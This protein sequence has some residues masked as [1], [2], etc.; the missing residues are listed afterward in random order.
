MDVVFMFDTFSTLL[1]GIPLTLNLAFTSLGVGAALA[2]GLAALRMSRFFLLQSLARSYVF[3]FRGTPLLIQIFLIYY[4]LGQFRPALQEWGLWGFFRDPYWCVIMAISLNTAAYAS[5]I[6][7]GAINAVPHPQVEAARSLGMSGL[8]LVRRIYFPIALRMALPAYGNEIMLVIKATSLA[9]IVTLME[10]T[11]IAAK[12]ILDSFRTL[13]VFIV[14]GVIYFAMNFLIA[15]SIAALEWWL[16]P[17]RLT[18]VS[19]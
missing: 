5:E 18:V 17:R 1:M 10:I 16:S 2:I 11:G 7:R 12:L 9:S 3:V 14:A 8:L 13:E 6:V 19:R 4:G 15:N